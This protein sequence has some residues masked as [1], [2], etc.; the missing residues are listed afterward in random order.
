MWYVEQAKRSMFVAH[1]NEPGKVY[2][3]AVGTSMKSHEY[4]KYTARLGELMIF[5]FNSVKLS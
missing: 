3:Y 5:Y 4:Y 1:H 2:L